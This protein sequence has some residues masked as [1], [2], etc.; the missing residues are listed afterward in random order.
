MEQTNTQPTTEVILPQQTEAQITQQSPSISDTQP[1]KNNRKKITIIIAAV[2]GALLLCCC[3]VGLIV[4]VQA[5][6]I[7]KSRELLKNTLNEYNVVQDSIKEIDDAQS[8]F[9]SELEKT[10][11]AKATNLLESLNTIKD[12]TNR[13]KETSNKMT[14]KE[15]SSFKSD[16]NEYTINLDKMFEDYK[17]ILDEL[18]L[19]KKFSSKIESVNTIMSGGTNLS[20]KSNTEILLFFDN[21]LIKVEEVK[22]A[23]E[24]KSKVSNLNRAYESVYSVYK[25]FLNDSKNAYLTSNISNL[26]RSLSKFTTTLSSYVNILKSEFQVLSK[27][28]IKS[29]ETTKASVI[30]VTN[31]YDQIPVTYRE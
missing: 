8:S 16:L 4:A 27:K 14:L 24:G 13:L 3:T 2:L 21:A 22:A 31:S 7:Q 12:K 9:I 11:S 26:K 23:Y 20:S 5:A 1:K 6:E 30:K 25:E 28:L 18:I 17:N 19:T 29:I 10:D 15:F